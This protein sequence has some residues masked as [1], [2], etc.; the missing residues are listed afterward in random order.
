MRESVLRWG[1]FPA[2]LLLPY[3]FLGSI[4]PAFA[5]RFSHSL[6]SRGSDFFFERTVVPDTI[7]L[8]AVM[9]QFQ[10]DADSRTTGDGRFDLSAGRPDSI[11]DPPPRDRSYFFNHLK[12]LE[13]YFA[14]VSD[15]K[16]RIKT[17]VLQPVITL[18]KQM[19]AYSPQSSDD[20]GRLAAL[21]DESWRK[22]DSAVAGVDFSR[23][24]SFV[25]FH[26]GAGRDINLVDIFGFD[27]TPFDIPSVYLGLPALRQLFGSS[28][29]GVPVN[30]G[31]AFITNSM[32]IPETENRLLSLATGPTVLELSINGL[33][34]ASF[35]SFLGLPDLF[36][37]RTG[38]S[39]IGRFG[40]MD[41][42]AIFSFNGLFPPEPSAWEKS[43]LGWV[44]PIE[45]PPGTSTQTARAVGFHDGAQT[46]IY[47]VPINA[48]EYF[49][50]ENRNRDP[51]RDG[52]TVRAVV[53]G[54]I[55][56]SRFA[57]DTV[58]FNATDTRAIRGVVIEVDDY[59]WSL[60]GGVD[61][62]GNFFDGGILIW[63]IDENVIDVNLSTNTVNANSNLRGV[64]LEEADGS[65]D[66]GQI[67]DIT[68]PGAGS[69]NGTALD[70]WY[71]GNASPVN[72]NAFTPT[73]NPNSLSNSL[74]NSHI[75]I[76]DF[77]E[78][79]AT[80][81]FKVR[82]GDDFVTPL[83]GF[84]KFLGG[85]GSV[86]APVAQRSGCLAI[87][88]NFFVTVNSKVY[89]FRL[90]GTSLTGDS[91]G[92]FD[93]RGA[94]FQPALPFYCTPLIQF[95]NVA[96][97]SDSSVF[98]W[99]T[100]DSDGDGR[101][102]LLF[103]R[104]IGHRVTAPPTVTMSGG[105]F[106]ILVGDADGGVWIVSRDSLSRF[107]VSAQRPVRTILNA[108]GGW[109]AIAEDRAV[110]QSGNVWNFGGRN[111]RYAAGGDLDGDGTP[112]IVVV[113]SGNEILV[114]NQNSSTVRTLPIP[115]SSGDFSAL[116]IGDVDGDGKKEVVI[117]KGNKIFAL[118]S[119]GIPID[120]FPIELPSQA[121]TA[122]PPVLARLGSNKKLSLFVG[123]SAGLVYGFDS[124]GKALP[125]FPLAAGGS[126]TN[127]LA[128]FEEPEFLGILA[129]TD[130]GYL[131]AWTLP[132]TTKTIVW[133]NLSGDPLH[134]GF[135]GSSTPGPSP[136]SRDFLPL[137]RAYNW[138]NPVYAGST[139]IRYFLKSNAEVRVKIFDLAG[140]KVVELPAP[141]I[142]GVD[143]EVEWDVSRVQSGVYLARI[144]AVGSTD[145]A[146]AVIKIAVVK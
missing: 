101:G 109:I 24:Q 136:L 33:L 71:K 103:S 120:N 68:Q 14:K 8:L 43:F 129:A 62:Q 22:A 5:Q 107:Q 21:V 37:T 31:R 131:Y 75:Y 86:G 59:D 81:T 138:P 133:G 67:Y 96:G 40:L 28:Y 12:F 85:A 29:N 35:G 39:G 47:K 95:A 145:R 112:E 66:I 88:N 125:G 60:P 114:F 76:S 72:K 77:S 19:Q 48:K 106:T 65:Q 119:A 142:G 46:Q 11:I 10:Q 122:T 61:Q 115:A 70:F 54:Q 123:T 57:R 102:D 90:D 117:A 69:E 121:G 91:S 80:M 15:G 25:I 53:G 87:C 74:A 13:N 100:A 124:Q 6:T 146:S 34:A 116:A 113:T 1:R 118:N 16:V 42:Q 30:G 9:V 93:T 135:D 45:V 126:I 41:G 79:G 2:F 134:S 140:D 137:D 143:N 20:F 108:S 111:A 92:L 110:S 105:S 44:H 3:F 50:V 63:H 64:D 38:R 32:I 49:L 94:A 23:Y 132:S 127:S 78:R 18:S 128:L 73:S 26:A 58:R 82:I 97:V 51:K 144:E 141:G 17:D 99:N 56:E 7:R 36:D 52:Q 55:V 89:G 98:V 27:P 84:P 139:R 83:K 104:S 130:N 4:S